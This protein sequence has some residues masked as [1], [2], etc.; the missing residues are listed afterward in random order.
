MLEC[1]GRLS[2]FLQFHGR[3]VYRQLP[4]GPE[5]KPDESKTTLTSGPPVVGGAEK[6][7]LI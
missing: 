5:N 7:V 2:H 6:H 1:T 4:V 3:N